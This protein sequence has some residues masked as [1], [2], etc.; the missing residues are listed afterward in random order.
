MMYYSLYSCLSKQVQGAQW[1]SRL[2][3]GKLNICGWSQKV[4]GWRDAG[5]MWIRI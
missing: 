1:D 3:K 5:K 2:K 4:D